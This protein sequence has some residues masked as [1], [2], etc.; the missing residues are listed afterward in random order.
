MGKLEIRLLGTLSVAAEK[1][2]EFPLPRK[3]K[4]V[5]AALAL[6]GPE[7]LSREKLVDF[8]WRDRGE[9]RARASLRQALAATRKSLGPYRD[10]LQAD[11]DK[12]TINGAMIVVDA[13][14]F[15]A[16]A[17]SE[18]DE[19]RD[20]A[21]ALYQGDLLDGVPLKEEG[22]EAWLRPLRERLRTKAITLLSESLDSARDEAR[23]VSLA[24]RL[25]D[26][27]PTN[28]AAHRALMRVYAA[29]GR[30]NA[31]LK[32]FNVCRD[33]LDHELGVG[34]SPQTIVLYEEIRNKRRY[35]AKR[36]SM[37]DDRVAAVAHK[38]T[39]TDQPR[40]TSKPAITV[41][42]FE[43]L[44]DEPGRAHFATG[45]T[46]DIVSALLRHR[47]LSVISAN[48]ML[49][50]GRYS[51]IA[52]GQVIESNVDYL[53]TGSVR[54]VGD[55]LRI[56]VQM[57]EAD[58]G[59]HIWSESYDGQLDQ[60][61]QIQ[62]EITGTI[63]GHIDV[64]VGASERRRVLRKSTQHMGA[65]DCYHLGMAHYVKFTR[66][67]HLEALRLFT[68]CLELDPDFGEGHTWWA[69]L[70]VLATYYFDAEPTD[71]LFDHALQAAKRAV[72]IDDQSALFHKHV[73]RVHLARREYARG[74][75]ELNIALDL[76]PNVAG[77]YCGMGDAL[78]YE[79]RYEE[80]IEQ[81][82]KSLQLGP[83]DPIRWAYLSY[84]ALAHLFA[85]NIEASVEWSEQANRCPRCQY[86]ALAHRVTAL[87][88][89]G[90]L[91]EA[92][93][94]ADELLRQQPEFSCRFAQRKLYFI[95]R[96]EQQQLY[97][98][99]LRKAGLPD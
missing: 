15:E 11:P 44:S 6:A 47:W 27:E 65:W 41:M 1:P 94:V 3:N 76:N 92:R 80:A 5:L 93:E 52:N 24:S 64:E 13:P 58:S 22:F 82:E 19:D 49:R 16:L 69:Y 29:R 25:L 51:M 37:T 34:P 42:P 99:G 17:S 61:F 10:C 88:H 31:A 62:D 20:R 33:L 8:F 87:G 59:E 55:R 75:A 9:E 89:L 28:E 57:V 56:G 32:Q 35:S 77:I 72:E 83:R 54:K 46:Y 86:W 68:R 81:F 53:V 30:D 79:G 71:E 38:A 90:R 48:N 70:N 74:L 97:L 39:T 60:I 21:L 26:L 14:A 91:E 40:P 50:T 23:R 95:K 63:A 12:V 45:I 73:G 67:D 84:G 98:D 66:S 36:D 78:T 18:S 7:G 96:P 2:G 43:N 85:G 4:A